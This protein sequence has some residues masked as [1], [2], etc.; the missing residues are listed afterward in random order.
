M[1]KEYDPPDRDKAAVLLERVA[2]KHA[3]DPLLPE[4][5]RWFRQACK[6]RYDGIAESIDQALGFAGQGNR[7]IEKARAIERNRLLRIAAELLAPGAGPW[8]RAGVLLERIEQR[9]APDQP[10]DDVAVLL[11]AADRLA[12]PVPASRGQLAEILR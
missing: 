3:D 5:A 8:R 7:T 6:A 11:R 9:H 4:E 10:D 1:S 2:A 12:G